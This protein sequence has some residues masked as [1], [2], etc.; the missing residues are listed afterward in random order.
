MRITAVRETKK[1]RFAVEVDGE[2]WCALHPDAL[3]QGGIKE[4]MEADPQ[5]L[6]EIRMAS[7]TRVAVEKAAR[8]LSHAAA[9]SRQLYDKLCRTVDPRA[10]AA[11]V[12]RMLQLGYLDDQDYARRLASDL[13]KLK[14]YGPRRVEDTL[15]RKGLT[16]DQIQQAMDALEGDDPEERLDR[17]IQSRYARYLGDEKGVRKTVNALLR[18]GYGYGEIRRAIGRCGRWEEELPD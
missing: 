4:G 6:E 11:A 3:W 17:L 7:E 10:A 12:E 16:Q 2:F 18:R 13:V 1:G 14:G 15:R 8:I 9:T 5:A